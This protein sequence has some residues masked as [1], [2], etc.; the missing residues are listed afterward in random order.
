MRCFYFL[1]GP[2]ETIDIK[3]Y[4]TITS[5]VLD[6]FTAFPDYETQVG[7]KRVFAPMRYQ[8]TKSLKKALRGSNYVVFHSPCRRYRLFLVRNDRREKPRRVYL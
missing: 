3:F 6:V 8:S 4:K 1:Q 5:L 2:Y 7:R